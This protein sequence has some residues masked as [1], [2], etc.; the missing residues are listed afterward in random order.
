MEIIIEKT[1]YWKSYSIIEEIRKLNDSEKYNF[2]N[3]I[4][5]IYQEYGK[6][7]KLYQENK[8]KNF[9]PLN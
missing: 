6:L 7:S 3:N 5:K 1:S 2:E 4:K 8:H 9:I